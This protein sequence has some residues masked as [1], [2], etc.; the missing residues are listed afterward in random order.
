MSRKQASPAALRRTL[1]IIRPHVG[2]HKLLMGGGITALLFEVV[3]R[4]LEPWPVKFVVDA[5][6][7]SLGA[8][9]AGS[10]PTATPVLLLSCALATI[11]IVGFRALANYL[12]TVAFAL[13]G[14]R[15]AA[16]LR[17]RVFSHVQALSDRYHS[18]ARTGDTVQRLVGDIG[19]LQEVAVTAGLPLVANVITLVVMAG[20]MFWLDPLL[21]LVVVLAAAAFLLISRGSTGKITAASRK[22]RKG[23]GALANTAQESL[24]AIRVVQA[25]GLER[26]LAGKFSN[27]NK[28][29]LT[30]GVQARRLAAGLERRT[31]VIVGVATAAVLFGGGMRVAEAAMTP[32]DLVIFLTY[33]KTAMKPLRDLAKYTG[34]IARATASGERVADLLDERVDIQD[35]PDA[36][37]LSSVRGEIRLQS[38]RAA[39][40]DG[41]PVLHHVNLHIPAGQKVAV[42]GPSGS[43]KS[44]LA[45]LL[46]RMMD[47]VHGCVS[48]DGHDLREV[49]LASLRSQVSLLL[50][51]SV[52]FTGSIRD[53]IRYGRMEA[54]DEEVEQAA[55]RAQAHGFIMASS[56]GYDTVVGERGSTLS[57]GQRQRLAI[58]RA[59]LRHAPVVVLD[60]AT[61]GL[62]PEAASEVL[63]ALGTLTEGRTTVTITHDAGPALAADRV[64]WVQDG[65]VVLDGTPGEL[66]EHPSGTFKA[67]V[68]QQQAANA[69]EARVDVGH[70]AGA[71][72]VEVV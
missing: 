54:T 65:N 49:T 3:F 58:A 44:T 2:R 45:S 61:T 36:V 5:V 34:R 8:D 62:D 70:P 47:P 6:T 72:V 67:W 43:G 32:G 25:Y 15:V 13:A 40:G 39:Y 16:A 31:D 52:L 69:S 17:V 1:G 55:R 53:N 12:A 19:R 21:A 10:G 22:T 41:R 37:E 64:L 29:A 38:V 20:V 27:S 48:V 33:L 50:Q 66:L 35:A 60:E 42:V 18:S 71:A 30:E 28:Q 57:G 59:L 11:C 7:R 14:S 46:V 24:G 4:V 23:E 68:E 51:D 9:L 63:A 26:V 56:N